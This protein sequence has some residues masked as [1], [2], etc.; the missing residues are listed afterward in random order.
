MRAEMARAN[1][2]SN[3]DDE[4]RVYRTLQGALWKLA[5]QQRPTRVLTEHSGC[6]RGAQVDR[7]NVTL[8]PGDRV[9]LEMGKYSAALA[10]PA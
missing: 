6:G 9:L 10:E 3:E 1:G 5:E 8:H 7:I 2:T 4:K